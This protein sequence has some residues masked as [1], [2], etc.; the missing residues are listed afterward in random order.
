MTVLLRG[1]YTLADL[2]RMARTAVVHAG[3]MATDGRERWDEARSAIAEFLY[4]SD[5]AP[6]ERDLVRVGRD[7]IWATMTAVRH[8]HGYYRDEKARSWLEAGSGPRFRQF[9]RPVTQPTGS[10]EDRVVERLALSQIV[11]TLTPRQREVVSALAA[12]DDHAPAMSALG[13]S[14]A[15]FSVTLSQARRRFL[16]HWHEGE[17]PSGPWGRDRRGGRRNGTAI[18][19]KRRS[20]A[21]SQAVAS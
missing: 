18:V 8:H 6:A 17:V 9:W 13:M 15:L 19:R 5:H 10:H 2:A 7:A 4:S 21:R 12:F 16:G 1:G 20:A 14:A 3:P 11:P